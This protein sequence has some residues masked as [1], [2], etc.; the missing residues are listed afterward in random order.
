MK[1]LNYK[2][3][4][5]EEA[6]TQLDLMLEDEEKRMII[7]VSEDEFLMNSHF[8]L[9]I[10]IRNNWDIWKGGELVNSLTRDIDPPYFYHEDDLSSRIL[11]AYY[12]HLKREKK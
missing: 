5:L 11:S 2:P 1:N 12:R 4:N 7:K 8:G 10:W 9:G 3:K 6:I